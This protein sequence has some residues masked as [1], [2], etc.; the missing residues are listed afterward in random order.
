[1]YSNIEI[2]II[3]AIFEKVEIQ[4]ANKN[5]ERV[6][7]HFWWSQGMVRS[8]N[9]GW[10]NGQYN[11]LNEVRLTGMNDQIEELQN[12]GKLSNRI[13]WNKLTLTFYPDGTFNAQYAWDT[14]WQ[15]LIE[16][17]EAQVAAEREAERLAKDSNSTQPNT[18][19]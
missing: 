9:Y 19:N 11:S 5:W 4:I 6:E 18:D 2:E 3:S 13:A 14:E 8:K 16:E 10:Y 7:S 15:A 1:M 12:A 17:S